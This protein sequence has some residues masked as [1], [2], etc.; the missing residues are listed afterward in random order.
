KELNFDRAPPVFRYALKVM[1][2]RFYLYGMEGSVRPRGATVRQ[3]YSNAVLF[4]RFLDEMGISRLDQVNTL[5]T[6]Q[7]VD[8]CCSKVSS[9][10]GKRLGSQALNNRFVALEMMCRLSSY[11]LDP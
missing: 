8:V 10:T 1:V 2:L 9:Q 5:L 3:F 7:Y 11:T 4:L 6:S